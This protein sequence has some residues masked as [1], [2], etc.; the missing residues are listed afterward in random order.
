MKK[1]FINW[2][3]DQRLHSAAPDLGL[4]CLL[5]SPLCDT[6]YNWVNGRESN[7]VLIILQLELLINFILKNNGTAHFSVER[8]RLIS[9]V[10]YS[11]CNFVDLIN[12]ENSV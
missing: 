8:N 5:Y 2:K 4:Q 3:P 9:T 7:N 6:T 11:Q 12:S 1:S 10:S